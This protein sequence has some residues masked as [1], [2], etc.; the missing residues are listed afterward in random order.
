MKLPPFLTMALILIAAVPHDSAGNPDA[1][2]PKSPEVHPDGRVTFRLKAP[3]AESVELRSRLV[4]GK[5]P[6]QKGADGLWTLTIGPAAPGIY[7]YRFE[8]DGMHTLDPHNRWVKGWRVS[9]NL[10]EIPADPPAPWQVADVPHG[11][12]HRHAYRSGPLKTDRELLVYTPPGYEED[13]ARHYPVLYLLHGSGDD[14]TAWTAVGRAHHIADHLIAAG[15]VEPLVIVMPYGHGHRPGVEMDAITDR[16]A[17]SRENNTAVF[18]D[19]FQ[20]VVPLAE[21]AYRL[22]P[23]AAHT[24][25][26]GLSMGGGQAMELGLNHPEKFGWVAGFSSGVP[27]NA[28]SAAEQFGGLDPGATWKK[29]WIACGRDDFLLERNDFFHSWLKEKGIEHDYQ[30]TEGGHQWY[31]WRDYLEQWLSMGLFR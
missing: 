20:S 29:V 24:A 8:V 4:D 7:P 9:E 13:P 11:V 25:I 21:N 28:E 5:A 19:F 3:R 31:V 6:L 18:A 30:L 15:K 10:V 26:A 14:A 23:G 12:V 22:K 27:G 17:W 2:F 16:A 1:G